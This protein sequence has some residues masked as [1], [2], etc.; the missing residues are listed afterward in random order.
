MS[1]DVDTAAADDGETMPAM[2]S[3]YAARLAAFEAAGDDE[4]FVA[5]CDGDAEC[6]IA[7]NEDGS[8][9]VTCGDATV[10]VPADVIADGIGEETDEGEVPASTEE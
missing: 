9:T 3:G 4:A 1:I 8:A 5:G 6:T 7:L 2:G 10:E